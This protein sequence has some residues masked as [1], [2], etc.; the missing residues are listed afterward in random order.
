MI[1][2]IS[3]HHVKKVVKETVQCR[4][5]NGNTYLRTCLNII[6]EDGQEFS[7]YLY[8]E[9]GLSVVDNTKGSKR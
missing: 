9:T 6:G 4:R 5:D 3:L 2:D 7:V 1:Y 8:H